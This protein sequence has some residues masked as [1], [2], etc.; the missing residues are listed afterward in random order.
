MDPGL[1]SGPY[2]CLHGHKGELR[3]WQA[4]G[5]T[6]AEAVR[7]RGDGSSTSADLG[8]CL[9]FCPSKIHTWLCFMES[10]HPRYQPPCYSSLS[11]P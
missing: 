2:K 10:I 6:G 5:S 11:Q 4:Y 1:P 3:G 8:T 9:P 7:P